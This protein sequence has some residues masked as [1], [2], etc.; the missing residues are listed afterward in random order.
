MVDITVMWYRTTIIPIV[1]AIVEPHLHSQN[2]F[3]NEL[4]CFI[5]GADNQIP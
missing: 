4:K 2:L 1:I 5:P 3:T